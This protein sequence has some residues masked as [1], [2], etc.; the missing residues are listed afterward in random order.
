M[1]IEDGRRR[2][3]CEDLKIKYLGVQEVLKWYPA[4][5]MKVRDSEVNF[6]EKILVNSGASQTIFKNNECFTSI[7]EPTI[8]LKGVGG[9]VSQRASVG[10]LK[11]NLFQLGIGVKGSGRLS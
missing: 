10:V 8:S 4:W 1:N 5:V 11:P 3:K 2:S 6:S 7:C 9:E